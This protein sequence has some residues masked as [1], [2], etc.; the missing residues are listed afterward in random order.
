M[1]QLKKKFS[2]FNILKKISDHDMM[3]IS[4]ENRSEEIMGRKGG[5]VWQI[6]IISYN[7]Y[8]MNIIL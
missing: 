3:K 5:Q 8:R 2:L 7:V 6:R 4:S 1:S